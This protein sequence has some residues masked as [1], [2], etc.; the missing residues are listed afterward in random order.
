MKWETT[1]NKSFNL[2]RSFVTRPCK[3]TRA[4]SRLR[5]PPFAGEAIKLAE[6]K[7]LTHNVT[8]YIM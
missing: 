5:Q 2:T 3:A 7:H 6:R 4:P 1:Y 8:R